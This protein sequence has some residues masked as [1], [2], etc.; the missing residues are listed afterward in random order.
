MKG[1]DGQ[2]GHHREPQPSTAPVR[3]RSGALA[4]GI[5]GI[6]LLLASV[7]AITTFGTSATAADQTTAQAA[8][9]APSEPPAGAGAAA[10]PSYPVPSGAPYTAPNGGDK[11]TGSS[12][13]P[14]KSISVAVSRAASGGT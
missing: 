13:A 7:A 12:R 8:V 1:A 2:M 3:R 6:G 4:G 9:S 11:A 14:V 5:G 10:T